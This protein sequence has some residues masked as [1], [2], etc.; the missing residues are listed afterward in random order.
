MATAT[1][2]PLAATRPMPATLEATCAWSGTGAWPAERVT[3]RQPA[4]LDRPDLDLWLGVPAAAAFRP[5]A[6]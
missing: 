2:R 1:A 3:L 4:N 6:R 5:R